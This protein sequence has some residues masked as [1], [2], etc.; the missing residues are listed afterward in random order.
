MRLARRTALR[1]ADVVRVG[2]GPFISGGGYPRRAREGLFQEA[3]HRHPAREFIDGALAVPSFVSGELDISGMTAAAGLFNSVAKGAPLVIILD[4][5]NNR[6]GFGYTVDQ[7]QPGALRPGRSLA[8]RFRQAQRQ[9]RRRR[10]ARQHQSVQRGAGAAEGRPRPRQGRAVDRQRRP[11]RPDE[12]A[13]RRSSSTR[14]ISP[15]SSA[16]SPRT[17]NGARSSP[18]AT[19]SRPARRSPPSRCARISWQKNRDVVIRYAMAY[20][21]GVEGIQRRRGRPRQASGHRRDPR[22]DHGAQQ[23][24]AGQGDR[25]ALELHQRGRHAARRLDHEDAGLLE[26]Q[27]FIFVEKKVTREQLFDL[28]IAKEAEERLA[29]EKPFGP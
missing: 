2:E 19:R 18:P 17:T 15:I 21:Q 26:R 28:S 25:P 8:G 3:R 27:N 9:A 13:R 1:A 4:R 14:P 7:R 23:A 24:R 12:D 5:G 29:R 6:P 16:S 20:L 11:A 22:A 10:R